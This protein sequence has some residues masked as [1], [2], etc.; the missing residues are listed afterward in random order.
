MPL[1]TFLWWVGGVG[2][3]NALFGLVTIAMGLN[4]KTR[5]GTRWPTRKPS[6]RPTH[7]PT[8]EP[9]PSPTD[10]PTQS[11]LPP[12]C[13]VKMDLDVV[14]IVDMSEC[15]YCGYTEEMCTARK[16]F[17]AN[18]IVS[19][20]GEQTLLS[21]TGQP[22]DVRMSYIEMTSDGGTVFLNLNDEYWNEVPYTTTER[23]NAQNWILNREFCST[24]TAGERADLKD[25]VAKAFTEF[26]NAESDK[27]GRTKK[28]ALFSQWYANGA[29]TI[30]DDY[31]DDLWGQD[32]VTFIMGNFDSGTGDNMYAPSNT[33]DYI[34]DLVTWDPSRIYQL[35]YNYQTHEIVES[36]TENTNIF[37][38]IAQT[39]YPV[40]NSPTWDPSPDPTPSPTRKPS[41]KPTAAPTGTPTEVP[42][43]DPTE[44]PTKSPTD[45]PTPSPSSKPSRSPT[46]S[47]TRWPTRKPTKY[48]TKS[49]SIIACL[50]Q[51]GSSS[52]NVEEGS[53]R[54]LLLYCGMRKLWISNAI[55]LKAVDRDVW[56]LVK[57][58][59]QSLVIHWR[60]KNRS[61]ILH[62]E[63][64]RVCVHFKEGLCCVV[65]VA[66]NVYSL[67]FFL[68]LCHVFF[69]AFL[70]VY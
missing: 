40:T 37:G 39:C 25:A 36:C 50:L 32:R 59:V 33:F 63:R 60:Y 61:E 45:E 17:I 43:V 13:E 70:S 3:A 15:D 46:D 30:S 51:F 49:L 6:P 68:L 28:V 4:D 55:Q 57:C 18:Y 69:S 38:M 27:L 9:T 22:T 31:Y 7:N 10:R 14:I 20:K 21:E 16:E 62:I 53:V 56:W 5:N 34:W 12:F 58:K 29:D 48:P 8:K 35:D 41:W 52:L 23:K 66:R 2:L 44:D 1:P 47:P 24:G 11:P 54:E 42:S 26:E 64:S 67:L 19:I 65:C